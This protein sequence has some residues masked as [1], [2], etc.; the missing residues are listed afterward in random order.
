M[1]KKKVKSLDIHGLNNGQSSEFMTA[2]I[3]RAKA[4]A[5]VSQKLADELKAWDDAN[6]QFDAYFKQEQ[7]N[8]LSDDISAADKERDQDYAALRAAIR[9]MKRVPGDELQKS[10]RRVNIC[11]DNYKIDTGWEMQR[12]GNMI[13]QM[14]D[15][16]TGKYASDVRRLGL[17]VFVEKLQESNDRCRQLLVEREDSKAGY[18]SGQTKAWRRQT[19][20]AYRDF[21]EMLNARALV[22]GSDQYADFIDKLNSSIDHYRQILAT[23]AGIRAAQKAKEEAGTGGKTSGSTTTKDND[24]VPADTTGDD[25][26]GDDDGDD[27]SGNGDGNGS[28]SGDGNGDNPGGGSGDDDDSIG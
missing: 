3:A 21:V 24:P 2:N 7:K 10:A 6:R 15:D 26:T 20:Q 12:E 18:V 8:E 5:T 23:A 28:G 13:K 16:L 19:E 9:A 14:L 4:D 22:E 11:L 17:G 1:A 27:G 25:D